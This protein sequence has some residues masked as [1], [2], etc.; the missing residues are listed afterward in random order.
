L[1]R[2]ALRDAIAALIE[3]TSRISQSPSAMRAEWSHRYGHD[4]CT[5]PKELPKVARGV[6]ERIKTECPNVDWKQSLA[7]TG[8]F[9]AV[10]VVESPDLAGVERAAMIIRLYAHATTETLVATPWED[11]LKSRRLIRMNGDFYH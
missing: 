4:A 5:D 6:A 10:D 1:L 3:Q 11:F 2:V 9:D 7:T 8:R